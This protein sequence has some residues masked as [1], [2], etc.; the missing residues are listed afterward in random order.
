MAYAKNEIERLNL[1]VDKVMNL[2][3]YNEGVSK[4]NKEDI[5]IDNIITDLINLHQMANS[6]TITLQYENKSRESHLI[7]DK[8][9]FQHAINNVLDNAIKY[10]AADTNIKITVEKQRNYMVIKLKDNGIGIAEKETLM[11]FDKFYRVSTK[12]SHPVKGYGLGLNYVKKIMQQHSGWYKI[13]SKLGAGTTL[14][15]GW[16]L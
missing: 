14:I 10:S 15:L 12:N 5:D 2:A 11:V 9:Q 16:P 13:E 8:I 7:A 3:M 6:K 1:L 4:I